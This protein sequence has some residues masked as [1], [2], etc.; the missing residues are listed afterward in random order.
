MQHRL[1]DSELKSMTP[2]QR[3]EAL[4]RLASA[5]AGKLNGA[6]VSI[7]E[8]IRAYEVKFRMS[9]DELEKKLK[10][11]EVRESQEICDW[12]MLLSRRSRL[13]SRSAR[14]E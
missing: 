8:Q 12:L 6:L 1:S 14:A 5:A 11:R 3:A 10:A 2:E 4:S 13:E 7:N 9:S